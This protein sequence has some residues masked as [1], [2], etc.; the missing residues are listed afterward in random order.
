[1]THM[2][3]SLISAQSTIITL[4]NQG[5]NTEECH[6]KS[7]YLIWMLVFTNDKFPDRNELKRFA[8]HFIKGRIDSLKKDVSHCLN[9]DATFP[10]LLYCMSVIYLLGEL[11][12]V[13]S[14]TNT[15]KSIMYMQEL[16][17]YTRVQSDLV[18]KL[19]R[20]KLV[21][22][23]Q[24]RPIAVYPENS[25]N[26]VTWQYVHSDSKM[27]LL[28]E[29]LPP[30]TKIQIIPGWKIEVNQRFTIGIWQLV[31]D[32][33]NSVYRHGGFLDKLEHRQDLQTKFSNFIEGIYKVKNH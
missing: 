28:L 20:H 24:P 31:E 18:M 6:L 10:A 2:V 7:A 30:K 9:G 12:A 32:I 14:G 29:E 19:F 27:H 4:Y 1:M 11:N 33:S 21:H 13:D 15:T 26:V 8:R 5:N 16:M 25:T 3:T 23:A 22:L 17:G